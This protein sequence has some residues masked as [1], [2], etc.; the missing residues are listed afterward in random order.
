MVDVSSIITYIIFIMSTK[1][2]ACLVK[3]AQKKLTGFSFAG[4]FGPNNKYEDAADLF[5]DA[6]KQYKICEA[7][8]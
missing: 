5:M 3:K 7:C 1:R 4:L 8:T 2:A 6:A